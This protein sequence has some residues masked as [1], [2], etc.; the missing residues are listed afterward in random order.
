MNFIKTTRTEASPL[1]LVFRL[2]EISAAEQLWND[3]ESER[4]KTMIENA[5]TTF[6]QV[7]E[8]F[9]KDDIRINVKID[10]DNYEKVITTLSG[11]SML[12]FL[13]VHCLILHHSVLEKDH[14]LTGN[15]KI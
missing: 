2:S 6:N 15:D 9:G 12:S 13:F 8:N 1:I 14:F 7:G 10:K 5:L 4:L 11:Q 3:F